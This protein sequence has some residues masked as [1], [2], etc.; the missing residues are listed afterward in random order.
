MM[1]SEG[2][3]IARP[4]GLRR[5]T[6]S[7]ISSILVILLGVL[8][9]LSL[10]S[11]N[12]GENLIGRLGSFIYSSLTFLVGKYV[13]HFVPITI[14]AGGLMVLRGQTLSQLR[15]RTTGL[16]LA[17]MGLCAL[18]AM[19]Y[20]DVDLRTHD[21]FRVG[22][23]L[24]N[25]LMHHKCLYLT[26]YLGVAGSYLFLFSLLTIAGLLVTDTHLRTVLVYSL[27]GARAIHPRHWA[28]HLAFWRS[29]AF[30]TFF[31][32][33]RQL[34]LEA[35]DD[36]KEE[37][38]DEMDIVSNA[39]SSLSLASLAPKQHVRVAAQFAP[40]AEPI[41]RDFDDDVIQVLQASEAAARRRPAPDGQP[42]IMSSVL[43]PHGMHSIS[44]AT[45][46]VDMAEENTLQSEQFSFLP[47]A[48]YELPNNSLLNEVARVDNLMSHE[49]IE[50]LSLRL[51]S[52]LRDF[53]IIAA[54]TQVTQ[55]PTVTRFEIQPAPGVKVARIVS[56]ENDIAMCVE[57]E[58]VRIIAPIP[59]KA[60]VGL[61]IPNSRP[62]PVMMRE[63]IEAPAFLKHPSPLAFALGKTISGEPYI[64][65]LAKMPHLLIA[66]TTGS[67]K[68]VSLNAIICSIL[69]RMPPDKVKFIMVDPKRVE[70]NVYRDIPHLLAPVVCEPRKAA[71]ALNW[72][73]E[74]MEDRY[75]RLE[76]MGVRNI[77]GYNAIVDSKEPPRKAIGRSLEYMPHIVI[78]IDELADLMI[79][80]RNEVEESIIRLAQMSRAVGMHL[81]IATQRPSV[82]V[83]TGIIKANF[84]SRVAFKVSSKVD[85][86]TI[87]DSNGA[88]ALLGRGDMLFAPSGVPKP[89]RLQ[90]CF[91]SD[92]EVERIAEFV[93]GQQRVTYQKEDFGGA[94]N[95]AVLND[96]SLRLNGID[97]DDSLVTMSDENGDSSDY[98]FVQQRRAP[99]ETT[100]AQAALEDGE[101]IDQQLLMQAIKLI[102]T[103]KKASVSMLQRR[104]KIGFARAGRV[105]DMVEEAG[106]VGPSIGSK[107]RDILVDP[108]EYLA[109][110]AEQEEEGF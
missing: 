36:F 52:T 42:P 3:A 22:G 14:F 40:Q 103:H 84:P 68:S 100:L 101:A 12:G 31:E 32:S 26:G 73:I 85:S 49:E 51:E 7:E 74:Q 87:L 39:F 48:H 62:T 81:I 34:P 92:A 70:L 41:S 35:P 76:A 59:G 105:M 99:E 88:E 25:F 58:S 1:R 16:F 94:K 83:I 61:E 18:A 64:C 69:Y 80:A 96:G 109:Q 93:R 50:T 13:A 107:V 57:A 79:I 27:R 38:V 86:R 47:P 78:V 45:D 21:G 53:G 77:D 2:S 24:G 89:I 55:G 66:G 44:L 63:I 11:E 90:G 108:E 15:A 29:P 19:P 72:A 71:A 104:L 95:A 4:L 75:K 98:S 110:L 97:A 82:N 54:V 91:L 60:A 67:G 8:V 56:L 5:E 30:N 33:L 28:H 17:I 37:R 6:I 20:A 106:I 46:L 23:A 10:I 43:T 102:L 9:F 65:D